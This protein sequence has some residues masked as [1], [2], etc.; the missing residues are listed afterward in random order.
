MDPRM[1]IQMAMQMDD[2]SGSVMA[3][4]REHLMVLQTVL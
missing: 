4:S 1:G 3:W 2:C